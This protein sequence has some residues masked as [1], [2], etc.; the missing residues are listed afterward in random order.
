MAS[1]SGDGGS[2]RSFS[3]I[4][5]IDCYRLLYHYYLVWGSRKVH[6]R[7]KFVSSMW[8]PNCN[9]DSPGAC[10][11][12]DAGGVC[13]VAMVSTWFFFGG[14]TLGVQWIG[15]GPSDCEK[16]LHQWS[17]QPRMVLQQF[18]SMHHLRDILEMYFQCVGWKMIIINFGD[19]FEQLEVMMLFWS[20]SVAIRFMDCQGVVYIKTTLSP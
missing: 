3:A 6:C 14:S 1:G 15:R 17:W 5:K 13:G 11:V 10:G 9:C 12:P 2:S 19:N 16:R 20:I 7:H 8:C 18:P 4:C